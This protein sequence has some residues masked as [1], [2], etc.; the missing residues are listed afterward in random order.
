MFHVDITLC[1]Y[2]LMDFFGSY[3]IR[4]MLYMITIY[5]TLSSVNLNHYN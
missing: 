1:V 5:V 3:V 2:L 4:D